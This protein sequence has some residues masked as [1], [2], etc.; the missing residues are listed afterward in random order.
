MPSPEWYHTPVTFPSLA[1]SLT[2]IMA[3]DFRDLA[4]EYGGRIFTYARYSLRH[5]EDAEDV[6]QEVLVRLWKHKDSIEPASMATWVMRV[7]RN[8]VIDV[9]RRRQS[10]TAVFAEGADVEE[11]AGHVAADEAADSAAHRAE[12]REQLESALTQLNEPY[13]SIVVMR[14]VQGLA[15]DEIAAAM[16]MP[17]GTIKVYLHRARRQLRESMRTELD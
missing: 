13:R 11:M 8:L 5:R 10:R 7:T 15:Y 3:R 16:N 12:I 9:A 2:R 6:T 17:L 4:E 14:E 1:A